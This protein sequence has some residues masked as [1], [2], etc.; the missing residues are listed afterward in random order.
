MNGDELG[1]AARNPDS[2]S[3]TCRLY[4][5]GVSLAVAKAVARRFRQ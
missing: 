4:A 5:D 2:G 1:A 3:H